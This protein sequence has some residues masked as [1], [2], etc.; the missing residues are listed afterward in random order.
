ML[1]LPTETYL[2][3]HSAALAGQK[4]FLFISNGSHIERFLVLTKNS[5][6]IVDIQLNRAICLEL[7]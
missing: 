2:E 1:R 5:S 4:L 3:L 7:Y 6:G